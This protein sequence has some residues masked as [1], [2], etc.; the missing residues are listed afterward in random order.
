MLPSLYV[1]M[2]KKKRMQKFERQL[3]DALDLI[4]RALKA[5]HAFTSGMKLAADEF[6]DPLGTEFQETLD[7]IN[8]GVSVPDA[9]RHLA[10]RVDCQDLGYFVVSVILQRETGGNL[11]E[12]IEGIAYIIRERF[13]LRG[14][15][16][17][18]SAEGRLSAVILSAIPFFIIIAVRFVNPQYH[19]PLF[20]E[21]M[22]KI[23]AGLAALMMFLGIWSMKRMV[24]IRV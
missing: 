8:F 23:M 4:S 12:V 17:V 10:N 5:G 15:V 13:K 21:P 7:E 11:A 22:G 18:L 14:K 2:K 9:L 20:S 1:R 24:N 16:R 19:D 6:E 3:P